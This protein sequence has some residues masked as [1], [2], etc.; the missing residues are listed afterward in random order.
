MTQMISRQDFLRNCAIVT[1]SHNEKVL[2]RDLKTSS[3]IRDDGVECIVMRNRP[4]ICPAYNEAMDMTDKRFIIFVHHDIYFPKGWENRVVQGI[5]WLAENEREWAV[6]GVIG[7][8]LEGIAHGTVWSA[9][10]DTEFSH[11]MQHP[12]AAQS[13]DEV[14]LILDRQSGVRFDDQLPGFHLYGT[15]IV[16]NARA[17]GKAAYIIEAPVVHNSNQRFDLELGYRVAY[18]YMTR[19]WVAQLPIFTPIC[20]LTRTT[21]PMWKRKIKFNI[22]SWIVKNFRRERLTTPIKDPAHKA[23]ELGYERI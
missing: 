21:F 2:E 15:D 3:L 12:I 22:N 8:D 18:R 6:L 7:L 5:N 4:D 14:V 11:P 23:A 10:S 13:F 16:Q 1:A 17:V 20:A 9:G 19:K